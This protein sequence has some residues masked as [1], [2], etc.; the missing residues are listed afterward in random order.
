MVRV[1]RIK[2]RFRVSV[3]EVS[4]YMFVALLQRPHVEMCLKNVRISC[5][6]YDDMICYDMKSIK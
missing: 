5:Y 3:R 1:I 6:I 2:V 4:E